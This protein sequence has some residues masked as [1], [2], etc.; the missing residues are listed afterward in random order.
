MNV[1]QQPS[2]SAVKAEPPSPIAAAAL[3][4]S[5]GSEREMDCGFLPIDCFLVVRQSIGV[6]PAAI[7]V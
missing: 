1:Q 5:A 7:Q 4:V 3:S 2:Y 6:L